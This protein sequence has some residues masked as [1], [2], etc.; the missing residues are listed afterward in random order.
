M[1]LKFVTEWAEKKKLAILLSIAQ[2]LTSVSLFRSV[3]RPARH[4]KPKP[5]PEHVRHLRQQAP[6]RRQ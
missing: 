3:L 2:G 1:G 4:S 5:G 6:R